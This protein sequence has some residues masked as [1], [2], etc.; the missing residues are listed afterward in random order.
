MRVKF[1]GNCYM[2]G[3]KYVRGRSYDIDDSYKDHWFFVACLEKGR[4]TV[5]A[6]E[7]TATKTEKKPE[8]KSTK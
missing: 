6:D 7:S 1:N 5:L 4:V 3:V 2:D 8:K